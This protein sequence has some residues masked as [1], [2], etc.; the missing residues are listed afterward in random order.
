MIVIPSNYLMAVM[1]QLSDPYDVVLIAAINS[2]CG[3]VGLV[4]CLCCLGP[5]GF[6]D[7]RLGLELTRNEIDYA[8]RQA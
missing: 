6:R 3:C 1:L 7:E 8:V 4:Q 5:R 2:L